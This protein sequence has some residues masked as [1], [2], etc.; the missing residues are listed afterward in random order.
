MELKFYDQWAAVLKLFTSNHVLLLM[1]EKANSLNLPNHIITDAGRTQIAPSESH[2]TLFSYASCSENLSLMLVLFFY[3]HFL[4]RNENLNSHMHYFSF[5]SLADFIQHFYSFLFFR[6]KN[7]D[8]N[9]GLVFLI[10]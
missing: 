4:V 8:G 10:S 3:F 7:S 1:Q 5:S 9:P 6:F 2:I